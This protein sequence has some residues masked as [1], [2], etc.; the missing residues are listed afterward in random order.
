MIISAII[1][2][3]KYWYY[4]SYR[5][6]CELAIPRWSNIDFRKYNYKANNLPYRRIYFKPNKLAQNECIQSWIHVFFTNK[7]NRIENRKQKNT[8]NFDTHCHGVWTIILNL[9]P[10]TNLYCINFDTFCLF[11]TM[12]KRQR[13]MKLHFTKT[14]ITM[15]WYKR[16]LINIKI[17]T[18]Q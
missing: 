13:S 11:F 17:W 18:L 8:S 14:K 12:V 6:N 15:G 2:R 16:G 9:Q 5:K 4:R 3:C 10:Y 1:F 7:L